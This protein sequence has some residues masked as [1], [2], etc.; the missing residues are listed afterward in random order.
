M[1]LFQRFEFGMMNMISTYQV[2]SCFCWYFATGIHWCV[3]HERVYWNDWK[4]CVSVI[5]LFSRTNIWS[6]TVHKNLHS[7]TSGSASFKDFRSAFSII[8]NIIVSDLSTAVN[9]LFGIPKKLDLESNSPVVIFVYVLSIPT[10]KREFDTLYTTFH[11]LKDGP[12]VL[13]I[14]FN[15]CKLFVLNKEIWKQTHLRMRGKMLIGF[16]R[17]CWLKFRQIK[18]TICGTWK[19]CFELNAKTLRRRS[20]STTCIAWKKENFQRTELLWFQRF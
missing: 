2:L 20:V 17:I 4:I 6:E 16:N 1:P 5:L 19:Y 11:C 10:P 18:K 3:T 12:I 13:S 8:T 15:S 7:P 14:T 9:N